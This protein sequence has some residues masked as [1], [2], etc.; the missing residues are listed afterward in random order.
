MLATLPSQPSA[1]P[2]VSSALSYPIRRVDPLEDSQWDAKLARCAGAS[3]F[4]GQSWA[5]VLRET[6][7]FTPSY[8]VQDTDDGLSGVL[9]FMEIDSWLT[10]RRGVSLPFTDECGPLAPD[11]HSARQLVRAAEDFAALRDWKHWEVRGATAALNTPAAVAFHG[12][13]VDL[14]AE[15]ARLLGRCDSAVRRAIRKAEGSALTITFAHSPEAMRAF[16]T[17]LC[18]TRRRHGLP[19]QPLL[20]FENIQRHV[21]SSHQGCVVLASLN[22]RPISGAVF[23]HF[24]R[25]ALFKFGASDEAFQHLRPNNLVMWRAI[26]WHA[27]AGFSTLDLGRTSL[28]NE[29]LR[30]FKLSWGAR[31][32]RIEYTRFDRKAGAF[33][34]TTDQSS[35]WHSRVFKLVPGPFA[36]VIGAAAYRHVA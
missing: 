3:F 19:P 20:F 9:P 17:L 11:A 1:T 23:F 30:R 5:R 7:G 27:R 32:R 14:D 31:E 16:Y 4:H 13:T 29:G 8:F 35:G 10:G 12:H 28:D 22:G 15:P 2:A 36:R 33:V 24:G 21:L 34:T 25:T 26:E 18:Q 6:Y